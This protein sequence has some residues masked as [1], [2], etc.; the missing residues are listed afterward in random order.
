VTAIG[1]TGF[2]ARAARELSA[3]GDRPPEATATP[4]DRL[5]GQELKI[6]RLI[7][8]GATSKEAAGR[9]F[10][11]PRTIDA[12][13]RNIFKKLNLTSRGQLRA[14]RSRLPADPHDTDTT[15]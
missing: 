11:S 5:T 9:L 4:F 7:A 6:A 8:D 12:H 15:Y 13:V 3:C 1:A 14:M 2:A 10:L